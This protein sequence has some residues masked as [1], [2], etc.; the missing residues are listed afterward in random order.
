MICY[1]L[2]LKYIRKTRFVNLIACIFIIILAVFGAVFYVSRVINRSEKLSH[3]AVL[4]KTTPTFTPLP[5]IEPIIVP[6]QKTL[7]GGIH[8]FQTFNNCGPA[9]LSMALSYYDIR[10]DQGELG[11]VLRPFQNVQGD[12]DD[13]SV[14]V[15][16]LA[17]YAN[18]L[19][20]TVYHRPAGNIET[21]Q[22]LT[23]L[24]LP[25]ITR[26]WLNLSE[27]IGH[28]RVVKGF[29]KNEKVII[30]DDSLQGANLTFSEDQFNALWQ[31]FN[32][33][34]LVMVPEPK[35]FQVKQVLGERVDS[36]RAWELALELSQNQLQDDP[37]DFY[38]KFNQVVAYFELGLYGKAVDAFQQ[39]E[40][41][42]PPRMLWY[43]IE[44][45]LAYYKMGNFDKVMSMTE[46]IIDNHNRAFSELY[47]IRGMIHRRGGQNEMARNA[48]ELANQYN[49]SSYW[50]VNLGDIYEQI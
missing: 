21:L 38:A 42:L 48:F 27:D 40:G 45:I 7:S 1:N 14:T 47:Y 35:I 29:D 41:S 36:K 50:K 18:D 22:K 17:A 23:S 34:F 19:G 49:S 5:T 37:D 6:R 24:D 15:A 4:L 31:A 44:P 12:N 25:V 13:K 33:E 32:Y 39:I 46:R 9:S 30:Q 10:K 16:E 2:S 20:L 3:N 11:R 26:T 43:Q 28:Y 8:V